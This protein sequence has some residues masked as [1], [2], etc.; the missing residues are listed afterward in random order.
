MKFKNKSLQK[1]CKTLIRERLDLVEK[2]SFKYSKFCNDAFI[3]VEVMEENNLQLKQTLQETSR[4]C[5]DL[6]NQSVS[7]S[8]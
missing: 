4:A 2:G 6:E 1:Q 8:F 7:L 5:R 3:L